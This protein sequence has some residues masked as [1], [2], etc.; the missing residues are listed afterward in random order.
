MLFA[1][2][3]FAAAG[4]LLAGCA[5]AQKPAPAYVG[6]GAGPTAR[7][8][9]RGTVPAGDR[10][11]VFV[12]QKGETCTAPQLVGVGD[13]QRHPDAAMLAAGSAQ[14]IEF[15]LVGVDKK[16][17]TVRWTFTPMSG[18]TYLLRALGQQTACAAMILDMT[19][20]DHM[21][22]EPSAMRRN[23][24]GS[25]C[26]PIASSKRVT[27]HNADGAALDDDAVLRQGAGAGDLEGLIGK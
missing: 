5:T 14:T 15:R 12:L 10:Y 18:K 16:V 1:A 4:A 9:V 13:A 27:T 2:A 26:L 3:K 23:P 20:A 7:F 25:T 19:D 6:P 22:P 8:L 21:R 17:C 11:G 24:T